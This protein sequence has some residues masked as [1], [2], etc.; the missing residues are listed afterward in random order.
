[1]LISGGDFHGALR[2]YENA[3]TLLTGEDVE[4]RIAILSNRSE[5]D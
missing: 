1:M 4:D 5:Y 3:L 2:L